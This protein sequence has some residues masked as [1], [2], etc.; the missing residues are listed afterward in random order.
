MGPDLSRRA[1]DVR[2][3]MDDPHADPRALERT[4]ALF[5][6]V[7][8]VVSGWRG[9]HRREIRPRAR[10]GPIRILDVGSGGGDQCRAIAA[11]VRR[12]GLAAVVTALDPDSRATAWASAHDDGAGVQY[13]CGTTRDL[14]REGDAYD[15]VLSNHLLH[16]LSTDEVQD[17]LNDSR[18]LIRGG[19]VA[20]H[21]DIARSRAAYALFAAATRPLEG[22]VLSGSFIRED[23]LLSI[24]RSYTAAELR[25]VVPP[26][27]HVRRR[28]PA[29]LELRTEAGPRDP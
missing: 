23:G 26:G 24:R 7:N 22:G 12:E 21:H 17:L 3:R 13:R 25:A 6:L 11:R 9:L 10:R 5:P 8:A 19:G 27:W 4:Y 18:H 20:L 14:V 16:H 15:V 2:E 28:L 29:R 1:I